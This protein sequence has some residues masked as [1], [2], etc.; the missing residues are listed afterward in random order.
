MH[1]DFFR[2]RLQTGTGSDDD[3][4][5]HVD[6]TLERVLTFL[7]EAAAVPVLLSLLVLVFTTTSAADGE[8]DL[9]SLPQSSYQLYSMATQSAVV[10]PVPTRLL[11][12]TVRPGQPSPPDPTPPRAMSV[13]TTPR[14]W[15][16]T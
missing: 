14:R 5:A 13:R 3:A 2:S 15:S 8:E 10:Q 16:L 1:Y 4:A 12:T 6:E 9:E 11:W 7:I